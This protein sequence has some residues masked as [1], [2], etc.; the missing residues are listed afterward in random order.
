MLVN[1]AQFVLQIMVQDLSKPATD[2]GAILKTN[3]PDVQVSY[4][5]PRTPVD[6]EPTLVFVAPKGDYDA[7]ELF[8]LIEQNTQRWFASRVDTVT[9][10]VRKPDGHVQVLAKSAGEA[11]T[12]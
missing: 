4:T 6:N 3:I 11:Q 5:L 9:V 8:T 10:E 12:S 1:F 7:S 2:L